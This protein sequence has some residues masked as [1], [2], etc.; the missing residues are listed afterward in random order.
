MSENS[1]TQPLPA[2]TIDRA[3][4][5]QAHPEIAGGARWFWWIAGL[6]LVNTILIHSGSNTSFVIGLGFTLLADS[7]LQAIK[8]V[9]FAIDLVALGFFFA[10]GRF[11]L[12]G[13]LWAFVTGI[14]FYLLDALIYLYFQD[15]MPVA[16]HGLAL[17]YLIRAATRLRTEIAAATAKAAAAV[18]P[19]LTPPA[20]G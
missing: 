4:L 20:Q 17:F 9:A 7:L 13:H 15:W 6:S 2:D 8:P 12:R 10:M 11:A 1:F 16:F 14:V 5:A 19:V 18:P 3:A